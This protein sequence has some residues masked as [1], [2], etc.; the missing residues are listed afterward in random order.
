MS[1]AFNELNFTKPIK[2][3]LFALLIK[4]FLYFIFIV[5]DSSPMRKF[6]AGFIRSADHSEYLRPID[7][8]I[9]KG[10]YALDGSTEPY[11]GRLP[12]FV[13]P[14]ILFRALLN[15][16]AALFCLGLF[17]L[18]SS[19]ISSYVLSLLLYKI[20]QHRKIF[21]LVFIL[22]N[23]VPYFWHY[24][25]TLHTT[26]LGI[27]SLIFFCYYIY[28]WLI[29]RSV[30]SILLAGFFLAWLIFLRGFCL[31]YLPIVL[32]FVFYVDWKN[33][34]GLK[35]IIYTLT[36]FSMSFLL[37]EAAWISRNFISLNQFIP[38]Q[39]SFVPVGNSKNPEYSAGSNSKY[40][41]MKI[42][43]LIFAWGGE[44]AWYFKNSDM[45]WFLSSPKTDT[46]FQFDKSIFYEGFSRDTLLVLKNNL[47][48]SIAL[49]NVPKKQDS[50]EKHIANMAV[51]LRQDFIKNKPLYFYF[52]SPLKR[53]KNLFL[54]N[55]TQDW[56]G[57]KSGVLYYAQKAFK[58]LSLL[59]YAVL[60]F[61]YLLFPFVS[62]RKKDA[63]FFRLLYILSAVNAAVFIFLVP[64]SHF[65]YFVFGF[66][67]LIPIFVYN[68]T[69]LIPRFKK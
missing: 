15:E 51:R 46:A 62:F 43:E 53:T 40:S 17:I 18:A 58:A 57:S 33:K 38:L 47:T 41:V 1:E 2:W 26:S 6:T 4:V 30:K 5:P 37:M 34:S 20:S 66:T 11:A 59:L 23:C 68:L 14:Y 61:Q 32:V 56:P 25:W 52:Y 54:Q 60:L 65:T 39:T 28:D 55:V 3:L 13:F 42:R 19:V 64:M 21:L 44:N 63:G 31:A 67:L 12:G 35:N 69:H 29:S 49:N 45:G 24:D 48:L 10:V 27:S 8:F 22:I 16:K 50:V 9:E 7:N 36:L